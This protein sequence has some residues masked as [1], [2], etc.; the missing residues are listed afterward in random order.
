MILGLERKEMKDL[1]TNN[2]NAS[3][4]RRSV[5]TIISTACIL[6]G[7]AID[8]GLPEIRSASLGRSPKGPNTIGGPT[9]PPEIGTAVTRELS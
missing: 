9:M 4:H 3:Y 2:K 8:T 5:V 1:I 7:S 6:L